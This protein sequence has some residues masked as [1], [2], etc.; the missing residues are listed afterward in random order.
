MRFNND[1]QALITENDR[2]LVELNGYI[3]NLRIE[4][5]LLFEKNKALQFGEMSDKGTDKPFRQSNEPSKDP[6]K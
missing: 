5:Q 1:Y 3:T 2:L 4:N 6:A